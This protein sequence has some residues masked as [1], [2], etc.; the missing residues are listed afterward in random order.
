[1][2]RY[3]IS[4]EL[5]LKAD[6]FTASAYGIVELYDKI[7]NFGIGNSFYTVLGQSEYQE[8]QNYSP[9]DHKFCSS[10]PDYWLKSILTKDSQGIIFL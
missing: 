3:I 8:Y 9:G 7:L 10:K 5:L 2:Q 4:L 6:V 1:M